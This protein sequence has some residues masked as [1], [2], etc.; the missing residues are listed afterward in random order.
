MVINIRIEGREG[1]EASL[2]IFLFLVTKHNVRK[3]QHSSGFR[4]EKGMNESRPA[5]LW[6]SSLGE[7]GEDVAVDVEAAEEGEEE[8]Q[9]EAGDEYIFRPSFGSIINFKV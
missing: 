4:R 5:E 2:I 7:V 8:V 6:I 9:E 3:L 1:I